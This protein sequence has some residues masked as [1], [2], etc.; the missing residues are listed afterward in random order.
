MKFFDKW[1]YILCKSYYKEGDEGQVINPTI[2]TVFFLMV[3][4]FTGLFFFCLILWH[5]IRFWSKNR[6]YLVP[7]PWPLIGHKPFTLFIVLIFCVVTYFVFV[8]DKR[9]E[10]IMELYKDNVFLNSKPAKFL[11]F[12]GV[13][14]AAASA[15]LFRVFIVE[16]FRYP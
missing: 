4:V 9:Y 14:V 5:D 7:P 8:K 1:F 3:L 15:F 6:F 13:V 11:A 10:S 12:T 16:L 2:G